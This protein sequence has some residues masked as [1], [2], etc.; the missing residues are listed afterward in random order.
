MLLV[1][2]RVFFRDMRSVRDFFGHISRPLTVKKRYIRLTLS[3]VVLVFRV[4]WKSMGSWF[5]PT[6]RW[7][8]LGLEG[9]LQCHL[10]WAEWAFL[11]LR[12]TNNESLCGGRFSV[13]PP[14]SNVQE[15]TANWK[16]H[17]AAFRP[18]RRNRAHREPAWG[19]WKVE[20]LKK[21]RQNLWLFAKIAR[22]Q[23]IVTC[24]IEWCRRHRHQSTMVD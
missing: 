10:N 9:W 2:D 5:V 13:L 22:W 1:W 21:I 14:N 24:T 23:E 6:T 12:V 11:F 7:T 17:R 16:R 15:V 20:T 8:W 19:I 18:E 3:R 4:L